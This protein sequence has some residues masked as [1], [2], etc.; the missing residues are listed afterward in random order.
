MSELQTQGTQIV[1]E[2]EKPPPMYEQKDNMSQ[3]SK[4]K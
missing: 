4:G 1:T 2:Q 3:T